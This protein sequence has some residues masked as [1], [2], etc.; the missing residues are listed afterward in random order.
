[1]RVER[2]AVDI[3]TLD[4]GGDQTE[5]ASAADSIVADE[6]IKSPSR[7]KNAALEIGRA[8]KLAK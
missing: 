5:R 6:F 4:C 7:C 1:M 2:F 8:P 3:P